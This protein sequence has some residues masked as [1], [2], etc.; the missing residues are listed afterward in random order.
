MD[1]NSLLISPYGGEL[2]DLMVAETDRRDVFEFAATLPSI[3]LTQRETCDLELLATGAFSPLRTYMGERDLLSVV[4]DMRL[5]DGTVAEVVV[6]L[7]GAI[8]QAPRT[9]RAPATG[10]LSSEASPPTVFIFPWS[11]PPI[12]RACTQ[13]SMANRSPSGPR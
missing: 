4:N 5:A 13:R 10:L 8:P 6:R 7:D 12:M 9:A 1:T 3:Q 2:V 11:R